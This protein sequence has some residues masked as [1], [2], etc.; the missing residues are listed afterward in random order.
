MLNC[1][2]TVYQINSNRMAMMTTTDAGTICA[3][4]HDAAAGLKP[5]PSPP[6]GGSSSS[7]MKTMQPTT[8]SALSPFLESSPPSPTATSP[9]GGAVVQ[10]TASA[11][12]DS[13]SDDPALQPY[14][15]FFYRD[16]SRDSD[17]DPLLPL[18]PPGKTSNFPA[19][20]HAMLSRSD[21]THIVTWLPHGRS[22]HILKP[23]AF[24]LEVIPVVCPLLFWMIS[25]MSPF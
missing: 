17:P 1:H 24:E 13:N 6:A 5:F 19:K 20:V 21:L 16:H 7:T 12:A 14:P 4:H 11:S 22:W 18:V 10:E 25:L 2:S 23:K 8:C 3:D 9:T 15:F